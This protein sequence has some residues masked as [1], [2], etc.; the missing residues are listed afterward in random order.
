MKNLLIIGLTT[1]FT[2]LFC[3]GLMAASNRCEVKEVDGTR[4]ILECQRDNQELKAG[5]QVKLKSVRTGAAV[6]GC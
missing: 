2:V 5:D 6:E 3:G 4:L 1:T